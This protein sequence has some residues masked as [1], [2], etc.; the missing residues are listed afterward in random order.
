MAGSWQDRA[1]W[2]C[3][4]V[5]GLVRESSAEVGK[6]PVQ[7]GSARV[8]NILCVPKISSTSCGQVILVDQATDLSVLS[9]AV[10]VEVGGVG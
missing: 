2:S 4:P 6:M 8:R 3:L 7:I 5:L 9:D 10:P 1:D